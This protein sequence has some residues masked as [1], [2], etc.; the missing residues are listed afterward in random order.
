MT[1]I[2]VRALAALN[3]LI[4]FGLFSVIRASVGAQLIG[5]HHRA[6]EIPRIRSLHGRLIW[7]D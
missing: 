3:K 7:M 5:H 1:V 4:S 6:G 2:I